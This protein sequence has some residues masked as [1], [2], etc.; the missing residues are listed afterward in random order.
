MN[1]IM[2]KINSILRPLE[3]LTF[4]KQTIKLDMKLLRALIVKSLGLNVSIQDLRQ[5]AIGYAM[6]NYTV[7]NRS[8]KS[9]HVDTE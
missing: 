4:Q 2:P 9:D 1:V 3:L 7:G 8:I 6:R 5:Y